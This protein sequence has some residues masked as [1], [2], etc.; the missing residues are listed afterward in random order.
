MGRMMA[1][2]RGLLRSFNGASWRRHNSG[3][4]VGVMGARR[5]TTRGRY[6][7]QLHFV[8][9]SVGNVLWRW[10]LNGNRVAVRSVLVNQED[11]NLAAVRLQM[12]LIAFAAIAAH[13]GDRDLELRAAGRLDSEQGLLAEAVA[14]VFVG[15]ISQ[16]I[17]RDVVKDIFDALLGPLKQTSEQLYLHTG[18]LKIISL[19]P[20]FFGNHVTPF[21]R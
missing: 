14:N 17:V 20:V 3:D 21:H 2:I 1:G 4:T 9:D 15:H 16:L 6:I 12:D 7:R 11:K 13:L 5:R 18:T 19:I 10:Y 8:A